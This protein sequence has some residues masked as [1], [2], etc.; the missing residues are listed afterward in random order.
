MYLF[1]RLAL[2]AAALVFGL[3][4]FTAT[5]NAQYQKHRSSNG[6][7]YVQYGQP[8]WERRGRINPREY[9]RHERERYRI[10]RSTNRAYRDGYLSDRERRRLEK[11]RNRYRRNVHRDRHNW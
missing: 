7:I 5:A 1:K 6:R 9:R 2:M 10:Y 3:G 11:E 4:L 8:Q